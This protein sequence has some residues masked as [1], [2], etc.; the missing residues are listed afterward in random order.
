MTKRHLSNA[1]KA[2]CAAGLG[3]LLS[4][5]TVTPAHAKTP[6]GW[7]S[8]TLGLASA[9]RAA[10]G[11]GV[12]VAVL[13]TGVVADHPALKGK[14][15]TGPDF[16]KDGLEPGDKLY[17]DHGTAMASDVLKVAPKA[18]ILSV[19]VIDDDEGNDGDNAGPKD[20]VARG[21]QYALDKGA[22]VI[23]LSLGGSS[24]KTS[25]SQ[26]DQQRRAVA[27]ATKA[28]VPVLAGAG[29]E[30]DGLNSSSY[31][32]AY[33]NVIS[34]AATGKS[35]SRA[36]FSEVRTYN[37]VAAP[38]VGIFSAKNTGGYWR[39]DGTSPA[40][41]LASGVVALMLSENDKLSPAQVRGVLTRTAAHPPGGYDATVGYGRVD[42]AKALRA[43]KN[44]PADATAPVAYK[45]KKHFAKPNGVSPTQ[46][47]P[48]D[49]ATL[50]FGVV[51][52]LAG[53]G[54]VLGAILL[55]RSSRRSRV[56]AAPSG[57]VPGQMPGQVPGQGFP[58][59]SL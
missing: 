43:A 24:F 12:K 34:V 46:H 31:P 13:D 5:T 7:E 2:A 57:Q 14:V 1:L 48:L 20:A 37:T 4:L 27:R 54:M 32:A 15:T 29:N 8:R 3:C 33:P 25:A 6:G 52:G 58:G 50:V 56:A 30:G 28:G 11:E 23:S 45:G 10:Q 55:A 21:M 9:Q 26:R 38:G 51:A 41:A 16:V 49:V 47:P 36:D 19:R 35:G 17:G 42:A 40:T 39:V 22:D 59:Q 44:P 18:H 53:L